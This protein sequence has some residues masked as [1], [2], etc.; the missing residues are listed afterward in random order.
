MSKR[1]L[2]ID[3][4][5]VA[6]HVVADQLGEQG[7]RDEVEGAGDGVPG[8]GDAQGVAVL[9]RP[10]HGHA[11]NL[12]GGK[13]TAQSQGAHGLVTARPLVGTFDLGA[14]PDTDPHDND[15]GHDPCC[16]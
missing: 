2:Q 15:K 14:G 4:H 9:S 8:P 13:D 5:R 11:A 12:P 1:F 3:G 6:G 7:Q 16:D 10:Y